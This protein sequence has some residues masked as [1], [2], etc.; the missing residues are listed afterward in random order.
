M[1]KII[2]NINSKLL[3][4][5]NNNTSFFQLERSI[6][7]TNI[8]QLKRIEKTIDEAKKTI[9]IEGKFI[10]DETKNKSLPSLLSHQSNQHVISTTSQLKQKYDSGDNDRVEACPFCLLEKQNIYVQYTDIP[11][12]RQ[13]LKDDGSVLH[14]KITGL[15]KRQQRKLLVLVKQAKHAGLLLSLQ[16]KLIDGSEAPVEPSKRKQHLKFNSYYDSYEIM[17]RTNKYL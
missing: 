3:F 9:T 10:N 1:F 4:N 6:Y 16:P 15:C 8:N 2:R 12:L 11:V 5:S 17:K 14:R 13:F 7:Q